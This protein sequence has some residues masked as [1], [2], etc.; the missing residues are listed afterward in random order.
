[1]FNTKAIS[2]K[3]AQNVTIKIRLLSKTISFFFV[4]PKHDECQIKNYLYLPV[5]MSGLILYSI[6]IIP[7]RFKEIES[8]D[9]KLF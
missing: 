4:S 3:L 2:K 9:I 7:C 1:M 8:R 6:F 5:P